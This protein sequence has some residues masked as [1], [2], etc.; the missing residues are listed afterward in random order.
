MQN[1]LLKSFTKPLLLTQRV[2]QFLWK[3][4]EG[5]DQKNEG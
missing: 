1:P 4:L 2:G 5:I 3:E